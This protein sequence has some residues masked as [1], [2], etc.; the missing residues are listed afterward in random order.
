MLD[1]FL[2]VKSWNREVWHKP[3]PAKSKYKF[4]S[5]VNLNLIL[6]QL[7]WQNEG[8]GRF[9]LNLLGRFVFLPDGLLRTVLR[10]PP[11]KLERHDALPEGVTRVAGEGDQVLWPRDTHVTL[12]WQRVTSQHQTG[13]GNLA[14]RELEEGL[15]VQERQLAHILRADTS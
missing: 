12:A 1:E 7:L 14:R 6:L 9:V 4:S 3:I 11:C 10:C 2:S 5:Y 8:K 15:P 13:G